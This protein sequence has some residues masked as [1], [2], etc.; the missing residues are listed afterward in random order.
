[1]FRSRLKRC[2]PLHPSASGNAL[3]KGFVTPRSLHSTPSGQEP[4]ET[5]ETKENKSTSPI[6]KS[7][8]EKQ[9]SILSL[10]NDQSQQIQEESSRFCFSYWYFSM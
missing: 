3:K 5:K 9:Q 6:E 7:S 8:C 4:K 10:P 1:M 2:Q